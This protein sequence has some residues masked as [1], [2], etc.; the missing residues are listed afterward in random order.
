MTFLQRHFAQ[1]PEPQICPL[2]ESAENIYGLPEKIRQRIE[3]QTIANQL[4]SA[5]AALETK[6]Q[7][8]INQNQRLGDLKSEAITAVES[9][10]QCSQ[11]EH[12]PPGISLLSLPRPTDLA[13]WTAWLS[14]SGQ[15]IEDWGKIADACVESKRFIAS[16]KSS[17]EALANN[18]QIQRE[19]DE[20]LPRLKTALEIVKD[21]R[22]KF[23]DGLYTLGDLLPAVDRKLWAALRV[24]HKH[25]NADGTSTYIEKPLVRH[26]DELTRLAQSRN[27]FGCHFNA[28][29]FDLLDRDAVAFG[30]ETLALMDSLIDQEAGWPR[31][32]KSGSYWAT[33]G[34]TRRLH[35]LKKPA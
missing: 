3:S 27:V 9:F 31:N 19:L 17:L 8:V 6:R 5:Q 10:V 16:L 32:S 24:E 29:S 2:C 4:K 34:E 20:V 21:E 33:A 15:L 28:L 11:S 22:R 12:L 30:Q 18:S 14:N 35:P 1:H 25:E 23:T 13:D 26:L 7:A